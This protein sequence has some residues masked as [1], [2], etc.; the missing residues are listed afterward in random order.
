MEMNFPL[1]LPQ[2]APCL[3]PADRGASTR[4]DS[5]TR[6]QNKLA[7]SDQANKGDAWIIKRTGR[8]VAPGISIMVDSSTVLLLV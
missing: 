5:I 4:L 6:S 8:L 3:F 7:M 1:I 2:S